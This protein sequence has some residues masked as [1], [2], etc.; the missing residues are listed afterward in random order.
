M[1]YIQQPNTKK[2]TSLL[3]N[4]LWVGLT[5]IVFICLVKLSIWQYNRGVEKQQRA[6]RMVQLNAE[7]PFT[8]SKIVELAK[9][10]QLSKSSKEVLLNAQESINDFPVIIKG[11]FN[12]D[13]LFL[14]DNQVEKGAL[15]YRV[16]QVVETANY[17][18]LVNLGWVQ[19]SKDRSVLPDITPLY[20]QTSF[21]GNVR[22][23]EQGIMLQAQNFTQPSWPLRVQQIE[24]DKFSTLISTSINKPLLPFVI[25]VNAKEDIG[26]VKNWQPMVMPAEKHL[27]YAF[28]WAALAI[29]WLILMIVFRI[30]TQKKITNN[31]DHNKKKNKA[32]TY[33]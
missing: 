11:I 5:L 32:F 24:V 7:S 22:I 16:L 12:R 19:G 27:G 25:Y 4:A 1:K 2:P 20:G 14:L 28:Q 3:N 31:T 33:D 21:Q 30:K 13:Y 26:Y 15:G 17:A 18:V 8:L 9:P 6:I 23:I 29:A 10:Y